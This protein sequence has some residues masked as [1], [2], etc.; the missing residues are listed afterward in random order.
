MPFVTTYF[1]LAI[2]GLVNAGYLLERHRRRKAGE[3]LVCPLD[4]DCSAVTESRYA[5]V[6]GVRNEVLGAAY[7]LVLLVGGVLSVLHPEWPL[8]LRLPLIALAAAALGYSAWL[9]W[10][11]LK[12]LR[13]YCFYCL[14]A[15]GINLLLFANMIKLFQDALP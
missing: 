7:Y 15:A 13:D 12:I 3:P 14:L 9:V 6:F 2:G 5:A 8:T 11:Q 1:V 10:V 4:H